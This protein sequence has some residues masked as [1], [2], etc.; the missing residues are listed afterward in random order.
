MIHGM[1]DIR[2]I[3]FDGKLN[4]QE[5]LNFYFSKAGHIVSFLIREIGDRKR[6]IRV[7][8]HP[9]TNHERPHVHIGEHEASFDI[10]TGKLLAGRCDPKRTR[11]LEAWIEKHKDDLLQL[12]DIA[13][14]GKDYRPIVKKIRLDKEFN[15][16]NFKGVEPEKCIIIDRVKI[17]YNGEL[18]QEKDDNEIIKK[19]ISEGDM[20]VVLPTD[21]EDNRIIYK[22][23]NGNVQTLKCPV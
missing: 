16:Y 23:I 17:W 11:I 1:I 7:S 13:K 9:D 12:W 20:C 4:Y 21:L 5:G 19:V 2:R 3:R 18:V 15:E 10:K 8:M 6:I 14:K 22:S